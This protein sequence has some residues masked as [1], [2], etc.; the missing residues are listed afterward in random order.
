MRKIQRLLRTFRGHESPACAFEARRI[1]AFS[2]FAAEFHKNMEIK[3]DENE[4]KS[5]EKKWKNN[6]NK[7][8]TMEMKRVLM[9]ATN[10]KPA[11]GKQIFTLIFACFSFFI[12]SGFLHAE[13]TPENTAENTAGSTAGNTAENT[14]FYDVRTFGAVGDG[15]KKDTQA[16][17]NALDA[18]FEKEGEKG[19]TVR[20]SGGTFLCGSLFLRSGVTLEVASDAVLKASPDPED[21]APVDF[22]PQNQAFKGDYI[23]GSHLLIALEVKNVRVTGGGTIDGNAR[24]FVPQPP[25]RGMWPKPEIPWRPGQM[26]FFCECDGVRVDNI[27]LTQSPYWTCFL[28]GCVNC[29]LHHI[30]ILNEAT[31]W[32]SD[33]I[34]VD[35]CR[36]VQIHDCDINTGDDCIT[37]RANTQPLK[38]PRP[39]EDVQVWDC[40]LKTAC[41]G[42]RVGVGD[43]LI[44]NCELRKLTIYETNVGLNFHSSYRANSPGTNVENILFEDISLDVQ[45]PLQITYGHALSD[46]RIGNITFR[47]IHGTASRPAEIQRLP[48]H[49]L[50]PLHAENVEIR[51]SDGKIM[52]SDENFE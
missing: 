34:D 32:N 38:N 27:F 52:L 2:G 37:L 35:C 23:R 36:N 3:E 45:I 39:C 15:V 50:G 30:R 19:G 47:N 46:R 10:L 25:A 22:C 13:N 41:Q 17:Q 31:I 28:H 18:C 21:Y 26:L 12:F 49:P 14:V 42:V 9:K 11:V 7:G 16:V 24:A 44:R 48:E 8:K 6:D 4:E 51:N 20:L 33:G 43:G 5:N 29:E 1:P 40:R